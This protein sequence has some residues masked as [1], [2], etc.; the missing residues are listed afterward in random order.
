MG[1]SRNANSAAIVMTASAA[2]VAGAAL[3]EPHRVLVPRER[4][5]PGN[6]ARMQMGRRRRSERRRQI[7]HRGVELY[8]PSPRYA[9]RTAGSCSSVRA[10]P[11][12]VI[13]PDSIT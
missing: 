1:T 6:D 3:E 13:S 7:R 9:A 10:S 4:V 11:E 8:A 5:L 12:I 2:H